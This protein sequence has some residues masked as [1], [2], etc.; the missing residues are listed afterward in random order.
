MSARFVYANRNTPLLFPEDLREWLPENHMVHFIAGA[1]ERLNVS[2]FKVNETGSGSG[3]YP[4]AIM[5]MVYC[6]ATGRMSSRAIE[7]ST[8][9]D[10]AV[11]IILRE[12]CASE[13]HG[14]LPVSDG[15]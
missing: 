8:Y 13:L 5:V 9:S 6:Y 12:P 14:D 2:K 1:V 11:R 3:Q 7:E 4:P 10:L 15:E